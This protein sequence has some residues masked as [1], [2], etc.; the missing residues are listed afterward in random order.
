MG[1]ASRSC[2]DAVEKT[3]ISWALPVIEPWFLGRPTQPVA[4]SLFR[5]S[6]RDFR[7]VM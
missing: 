4:K 2:V 6:Y 5:L 1:E 7:A 3:E